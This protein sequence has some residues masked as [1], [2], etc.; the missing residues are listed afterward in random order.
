MSKPRAAAAAFSVVELLVVVA[1][2]ALL[3]GLVVTGFRSISA[4]AS[5]S[6]AGHLANDQLVLA[7]QTAQSRSRVVELRIYRVKGR[8]GQDPAW[9]AL[10][11]VIQTEDQRTP[12]PLSRVQYLPTGIVFSPEIR[13]STLLSAEN[14][15][16]SHDAAEDL[17]G[18]PATPYK[19]IL[20]TP[21]GGTLLDPAGT[22]G[23]DKWDLTLLPEVGAKPSGARPAKNFITLV[24]DPVNGH[25]KTFQP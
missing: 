5:L 10:R 1:I 18:Q 19:A 23:G 13:Y 25:V 22:S 9:R 6:N 4:A 11:T 16:P 17:P 15:H 3:I 2:I 12:T 8:D 20:F 7:R 14:P 24:L 21:G